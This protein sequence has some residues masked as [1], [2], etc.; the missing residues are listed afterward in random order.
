MVNLES[1]GIPMLRSKLPIINQ[2]GR[3]SIELKLLF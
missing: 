1:N 3:R 2:V